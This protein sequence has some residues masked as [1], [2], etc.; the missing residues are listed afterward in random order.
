LDRGRTHCEF[1]LASL[2][3]PINPF[4]LSQLENG[5]LKATNVSTG[6]DTSTGQNIHVKTCFEGRG[7]PGYTLTAGAL[8]PCYERLPRGSQ[9]TVFLVESGL[10]LA[11]DYNALPRLATYSGCLTPAAALGDML[12]ERVCRNERIIF[13]SEVI[14]ARNVTHGSAM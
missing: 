6:V 1:D 9:R 5:W 10:A 12:L 13:T 2:F 3:R 7:D 14:V 4:A 8:S 11:L